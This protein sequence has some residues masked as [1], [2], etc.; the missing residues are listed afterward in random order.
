MVFFVCGLFLTTFGDLFC[1][2]VCLG[3]LCWLGVFVLVGVLFDLGG[4]VVPVFGL[5]LWS[6]CVAVCFSCGAWDGCFG[7]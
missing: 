1:D 5:G 6:L 3:S 2:V 4:L 7:L